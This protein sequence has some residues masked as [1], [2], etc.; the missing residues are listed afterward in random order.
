VPIS[1][2]SIDNGEVGA[3]GLA[4][5]LRQVS[6]ALISL[7][8]SI[9]PEQWMNVPRPGVWSPGKEAEHVADG[10]GY[11][12]WIVRLS[13]GQQV[14]AR[15]HIER[16]QLTSQRSQR[17]V[18]DLLRQRTNDGVALIAGLSDEQLDLRVRPLRAR[19]PTLAAMIG[20]VLIGHY[21][22]HRAAIE[23]KLRAPTG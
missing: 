6:E 9:E 19:S 1:A 5:R 8:G 17:D 7:V 2:E 16:A 4:K 14:P 15:P 13:L 23:A 12:Q 10:A 21:D 20:T 22:V 18:V 3:A 11:H